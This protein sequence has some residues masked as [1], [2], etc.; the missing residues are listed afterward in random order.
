MLILKIQFD[1]ITIHGH[2]HVDKQLRNE[3]VVIFIKI[4]KLFTLAL[5]VFLETD[6]IDS[7]TFFLTQSELKVDEPAVQDWVLVNLKGF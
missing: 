2:R 1:E 7:I 4:A 5:P 6:L 3:M